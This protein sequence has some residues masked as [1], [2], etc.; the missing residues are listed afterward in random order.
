MQLLDLNNQNCAAGCCE[1]FAFEKVVFCDI[2]IELLFL[3][4]I[5]FVCSKA[6]R[7]SA[8]RKATQAKQV[9][10][11]IRRTGGKAGEPVG[12]VLKTSFRY[13]SSWYSL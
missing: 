5:V 13:I 1:K 2:G 4:I 10:E 12:T 8:Q 9:N 11:K 3:I 7:W 6:V